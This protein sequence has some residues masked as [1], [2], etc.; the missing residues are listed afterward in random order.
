MITNVLC[1]QTEDLG[2]YPLSSYGKSIQLC[3]VLKCTLGRFCIVSNTHALPSIRVHYHISPMP[4]HDKHSLCIKFIFI[5][6]KVWLFC[7]SN[8]FHTLCMQGNSM[9][10]SAQLPL[11]CRTTPDSQLNTYIKNDMNHQLLSWFSYQKP[12]GLENWE[13]NPG[14]LEDQPI[15]LVLTYLSS[16][17]LLPF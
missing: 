13:L 16:P 12:W 14:L 8:R 17:S 7:F 6:V 3:P 5:S 11:T 15:H 4:F 10:P 2:G 9:P 1:L